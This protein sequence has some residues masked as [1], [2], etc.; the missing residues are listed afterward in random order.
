[1]SESEAEL[2]LSLVAQKQA[3]DARLTSLQAALIVASEL[4]LARDSRTFARI[5]GIAHAIVLRELDALCVP[6]GPFRVVKREA[7]TLRTHY[8]PRDEDSPI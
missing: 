4:G 7:R 5:L 8:V 6:G 1:M 2:F 3:K